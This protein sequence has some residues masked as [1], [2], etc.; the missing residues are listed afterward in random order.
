MTPIH[1]RTANLTQDVSTDRIWPEVASRSRITRRELRFDDFEIRPIP[2]GFEPEAVVG[3]NQICEK[4]EDAPPPPNEDSGDQSCD[5]QRE[6]TVA[7]THP[8]PMRERS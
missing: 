5:K 3:Q 1:A 4:T 8:P 6:A 7:R 2:S